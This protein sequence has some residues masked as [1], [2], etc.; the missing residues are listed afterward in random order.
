VDFPAMHGGRR[1]W[2]C[3]R[4]D[5]PAVAHWHGWHSGAAGRMPIG[6]QFE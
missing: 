1:V 2:L 5:E 6:E 3:W 4:L